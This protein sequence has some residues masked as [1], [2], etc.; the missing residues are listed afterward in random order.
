M[1]SEGSVKIPREKVDPY[2]M[3]YGVNHK[4]YPQ[5]TSTP[6]RPLMVAE[7]RPAPQ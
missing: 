5:L 2:T 1:Y 7:I 3:R 6:K 4:Q